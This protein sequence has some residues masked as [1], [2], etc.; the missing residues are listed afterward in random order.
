MESKKSECEE[1]KRGSEAK[2]CLCARS[3]EARGCFI[4]CCVRRDSLPKKPAPDLAASQ[5][6]DLPHVLGAKLGQSPHPNHPMLGPA[7]PSLLY[8]SFV[9]SLGKWHLLEIP[10]QSSDNSPRWFC[11]TC[12][13][14]VTPA[15]HQ[16]RSIQQQ[17]CYN[18]CCF[19]PSNW[20][21]AEPGLRSPKLVQVLLD[22]T[23]YCPHGISAETQC[24]PIFWRSEIIIF[25]PSQIIDSS[26]KCLFLFHP[27][28]WKKIFYFN[29]LDI[30]MVGGKKYQR[31]DAGCLGTALG[32]GCT[33][34]G[35][36]KCIC[37]SGKQNSSRKAI[38]PGDT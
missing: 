25:F 24:S 9:F 11:T 4:Q 13:R 15:H 10:Q 28:L 18:S 5:D 27:E 38:S 2:C 21:P 7:L 26:R 8:L 34:R 17:M 12:L 36:G 35:A 22:H 19:Q 6:L 1:F 23:S 37:S 30:G 14:R 20:S 31:K 32:K 33:S 16:A 3:F 29:S